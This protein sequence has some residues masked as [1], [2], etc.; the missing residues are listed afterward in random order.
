[1]KNDLARPATSW[2]WLRWLV[3]AVAIALGA[4]AC[5]FMAAVHPHNNVLSFEPNYPSINPAPTR[6]VTIE[7]SI[8]ENVSIQLLTYYSTSHPVAGEIGYEWCYRNIPL[9]RSIGLHLAERLEIRRDGARYKVSVVVDKYLPGD[10][11][12]SLK[13]VDYQLLDRSSDPPSTVGMGSEGESIANFS[14]RAFSASEDE[15]P[16]RWRGS[17]DLWCYMGPIGRISQLTKGCA[18]LDGYPSEMTSGIP[19]EQHGLN[20]STW[21]FPGANS[22]IVNFHDMNAWLSRR[23]LHP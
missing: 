17:V 18:L 22:V 7:G 5:I 4:V 3:L 10:C 19:S 13:S 23:E 14:E 6:I 11:G 16:S 21:I 20:A 1:M 2:R 15:K 9:G 8:A 12:W